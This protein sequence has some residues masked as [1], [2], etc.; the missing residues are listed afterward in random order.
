MLKTIL[1]ISLIFPLSFCFFSF[2]PYSFFYHSFAPLKSSYFCLRNGSRLSQ[3][4][5]CQDICRIIRFLQQKCTF[6]FHLHCWL[7]RD[8]QQ[9]RTVTATATTQ[10]TQYCLCFRTW[11]CFPWETRRCGCS[12]QLCNLE[13]P[14]SD[15][16]LFNSRPL[17][18][19]KQ[20]LLILNVNFSK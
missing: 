6:M 3:L 7:H 17:L 20:N 9:P 19:L 18:P 15:M 1:N 5:Y 10:S 2:L 13:N 4:S 8:F 14:I 11:I 16:L 12:F